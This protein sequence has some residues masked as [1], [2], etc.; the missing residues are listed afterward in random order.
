MFNLKMEKINDN[1]EEHNVVNTSENVSV[2]TT[3][4]NTKEN[5][6]KKGFSIKSLDKVDK[7]SF[8]SNVINNESKKPKLNFSG[9]GSRSNN[10]VILNDSGLLNTDNS[11]NLGIYSNN[12]KSIE[13][14]TSSTIN[15]T[16]TTVKKPFILEDLTNQA[17]LTQATT[18]SDKKSLSNN[19]RTT[20]STSSTTSAS[21]QT[22]IIKNKEQQI[23][24]HSTQTKRD[25]LIKH[26]STST[27][28]INEIHSYHKKV[29][30]ELVEEFEHL[31]TN[32]PE[33]FNQ[34]TQEIKQVYTITTNYKGN[35]NSINE[36]KEIYQKSVSPRLLAFSSYRAVRFAILEL[37]DPDLTHLFILKMGVILRGQAYKYILCEYLTSLADI[38][39]LECDEE[40]MSVYSMMLVL[41][42][43]EGKCDINATEPKHENT[44]LHI[45]V[46]LKQYQFVILLFKL[47]C[48]TFPVNLN[49]MTAL[50]S[51]LYLSNKYCEATQKFISLKE[52]KEIVLERQVNSLRNTQNNAITS[53]SDND[54]IS[55]KVKEISDL[56]SI[57]SNNK[58]NEIIYTRIAEFLLSVSAERNKYVD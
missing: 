23:Q 30:N 21:N 52:E 34:L 57:I 38:N 33:R 42:I 31:K 32:N 48:Y 36:I 55:S 51:A 49:D 56:D 16:K 25:I 3:S 54:V 44:P 12:I 46:S 1:S 4:K 20:I 5:N 9:G 29:A 58:T 13:K 43:N 40:E 53:I 28:D 2:D 6:K 8:P 50:D 11:S 35:I 17:Y 41:L 22:R 24:D 45:A 27:D 18:I 14:E 39:F 15:T 10:T 47:N 26:T 19:N 37:S 7:L